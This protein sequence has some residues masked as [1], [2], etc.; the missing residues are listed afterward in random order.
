M[1]T[2]IA[3]GRSAGR[4]DSNDRTAST[5][6][7]DAPTTTM[8]R[9]MRS[10]LIMRERSPRPAGVDAAHLV[11][12]LD[13]VVVVDQAPKVSGEG[14]GVVGPVPQRSG[15]RVEPLVARAVGEL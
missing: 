11:A 8:S 6:P 9:A 12:D 4:N 15:R 2:A 3:A 1:T 13:G 5:P 7:A 14:A 10:A